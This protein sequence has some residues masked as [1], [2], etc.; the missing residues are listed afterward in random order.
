MPE[1]YEVEKENFEIENILKE[2][3]KKVD[4]ENEE[5]RFNLG[6]YPYDEE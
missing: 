1:T 3:Q 5:I 2:E 6:T 4:L